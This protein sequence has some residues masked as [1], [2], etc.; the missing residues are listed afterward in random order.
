MVWPPFPTVIQT[1]A[2][3]QSAPADS[4]PQPSSDYEVPVAD[5]QLDAV[6]DDFPFVPADVAIAD[7]LPL[8]IG[9][10]HQ[11]MPTLTLSPM[12]ACDGMPGII[13]SWLRRW[14]TSPFIDITQLP[15]KRN[16]RFGSG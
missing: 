9:I 10:F 15:L 16:S 4:S 3:D 8:P 13:G 14:S 7:K 12:F 11:L 5:A 6:Y 2:Y 1:Y